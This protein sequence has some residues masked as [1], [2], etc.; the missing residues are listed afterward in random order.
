MVLTPAQMS[1]VKALRSAAEQ[2]EQQALQFLTKRLLGQLDYYPAL[3]VVVER[4]YRW[5]DIF[6]SYYPEETW[7]R[8]LLLTINSYGMKPDEGAVAQALEAHYAE[9]GVAN[10]VKALYD[11]SQAMQ[12]R[13]TPEARVSY[14]VSALVNSTM[15]ELVESYYGERPEA[16]VQVR[17]NRFDPTTGEASDPSAA[18][19]AYNFWTDAGT[20][21]LDSAC[22]REIADSLERVLS[23]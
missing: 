17:A 11:L 10:Y 9:A 21:A 7:A 1:D 23:R 14:L 12:D 8:D 5:L 13:H 4:L 6:E 2:R 15:A 18:L 3:A 19:I 22:W 20:A 16:W